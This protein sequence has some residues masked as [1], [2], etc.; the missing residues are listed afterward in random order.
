VLA[1]SALT[2]PVANAQETTPKPD[3]LE[4]FSLD[5]KI[6]GKTIQKSLHCNL[7]TLQRLNNLDQSKTTAREHSKPVSLNHLFSSYKGRWE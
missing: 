7:R 2:V 6:N 1:S 3:P 4:G 5:H